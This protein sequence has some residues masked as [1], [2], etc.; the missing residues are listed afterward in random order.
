M[1]GRDPALCEQV[2]DR[3]WKSQEPERVRDCGAAFSDSLRNLFVRQ[4]EI[5]DELL[6]RRGLFQ[7]CEI[8]SMEVLDQ[9]TFD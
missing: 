7:R 9:G 5:L 4:P 2:L 3:R 1:P 6:I 8:L